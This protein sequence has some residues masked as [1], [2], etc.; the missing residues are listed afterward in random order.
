MERSVARLLQLQRLHREY[1]PGFAGQKLRLL[2]SLRRARLPSVVA[3]KRLHEILCFL[4]A[5]PDNRAVLG[6][7]SLML[8]EFSARAD[9]RRVAARLENSGIAGT[10]IVYPF[11]MGTA[12][13]IASKW[14]DHL[15]VDWDAVAVPE[16]DRIET[17][18]E[19]LAHYGETPALDVLPLSLREWIGRMKGER[20]TDAAFLVRRY[21]A[22]QAAPRIRQQVYEELDLTLRLSPGSD[23]PSR[24]LAAVSRPVH[25]QRGPLD[26][27]R[28]DLRAD[29]AR[30]PFPVRAV[31]VDQGRRLIDLAR[32]AMI[33]RERDLDAFA[34]GDPRDVRIVDCGGG[35]ELVAIGMVPERRLLLEA[36]YGLLTLRNGI[37]IGYVGLGALFGSAEVAY[38]VFDTWR[39][40]EAARGY[41]ALL[42]TAATLFSADA[43]FATPYQLGDDNE[44]GI[45]SGAWWFYRKLGFVPRN[46]TARALMRREQSRMRRNP[47]YRSSAATLRRLASHPMFLW[48]DTPRD[49]IL[50]ILPLERVGLTVMRYLSRRFGSDREAATEA[51][52]LDAATRLGLRSPPRLNQAERLWWNR[53]APLILCL[54]GV[55]RWNRAERVALVDVVKAKAG[56]R[57]SDYVM[58]VDHHPRLRAALRRLAVTPR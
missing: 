58:K 37:P 50:G 25:F 3:V 18:L 17:W 41:S 27:S 33:T 5:L 53:W 1:G 54:P 32:E 10:A 22:L 47:R 30:A 16:R 42:T 35:L 24:T 2:R 43:F 12:E 55:E 46:A 15:S 45:E 38:N 21:A 11:F 19:Y 36:F 39:G 51:C 56:R 4:R 14:P 28:P 8:R 52:A 9:L 29:L 34:Y 23:T 49:D 31:S 57:E 13:W 26:S 20:E 7:V 48:R 40:S 6:T 44:E